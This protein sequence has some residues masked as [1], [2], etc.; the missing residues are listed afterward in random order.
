MANELKFGN[1]VIFL[2]GNPITLP[3]GTADPGTGAAGD[4]FYRSDLGLVRYYNGTIWQNLAAGMVITAHSGLTGLTAPADDHTQYALLAGRAGGQIQ[5]GGTAAGNNLTLRSTTNASKGSVILDETTASS[6][7]VTG[8]LVLSGGMGV[9]GSI[10]SG[11]IV[12]AATQVQTPI[13]DAISSGTLLIGSSNTTQINVGNDPNTA[14]GNILAGSGNKTLNI[15]TGSG[16]NVVNIGGTNSTVNINGTLNYIHST[17]LQVSDP[18][19]TVNA[20]GAAGSATAAGFNI[21]ENNVITGYI[22]TANSRQ[23][24]DHLAPAGPGIFRLTPTTASFIGELGQAVLTANRT[25]TLPDASGTIALTSA[26]AS[27]LPLAGGTLTG[28]LTMSNQSQVR[29]GD[30][31]S[32]YVALRGPTTVTTD[33]TLTLPAAAPALNQILVSDASGNLSWGVNGSGSVNSGT[34]GRLSLYAASGNAI[35]DTYV[36]NSQNIN[37]AVAAQAARTAGLVYTLPNPGNAVTATNI[38]LDQGAQT[39]NGQFTLAQ[40]LLFSANGTQAIASDAAE[41]ATVWAFAINHNDVTTPNLNIATT[42]NNGSI[43]LTTNGTGTIDNVTTMMRRST[44]GVNYF[45]DQYIDAMT[46]AANTSSAAEINS[47]LSFNL[48]NFDGAV[49]NYRIKE[50]TTNNI[51][52]G[53][54]YV[55]AQGTT[56][57]S[58]DQFTETAALGSTLGLQL[59][60]DINSGNVRILYNNTNATNASTMRAQIRRFHA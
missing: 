20:G 3:T 23:S 57:S 45:Q 34:A 19:I 54:F 35:S 5:V 8:A 32:N 27:Y 7:T 15:A 60:A 14:T 39:V 25:W 2:N 44:D 18:V 38:L 31:G 22:T 41:L 13:I 36:Q 37:I 56:V 28:N 30:T 24:Y 52:I 53:Q 17:Q 47:S 55:S 49:I 50:A 51:R 42:G 58:S 4:F 11:G 21:Q 46:L 43:I 1:K 48:T 10:F 12:S 29:Y 40:S 6:S 33:Y 16:T 9:A 26:F 59:T